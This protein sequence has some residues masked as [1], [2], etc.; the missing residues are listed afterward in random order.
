MAESKVV[1]YAALAGN[2]AI[3]AVKFVAAGLTGSSAMLSEAVHSV[4]D[5]V[6]QL[7]LLL[8]GARAGKAPDASHPFGYGLEAYFWGFV[9]ALMVFLLGGAVSAYEGWHKL[10]HPEPSGRAGVSY[11]VLGVSALFEAASFTVA[12]REYRKLAGGRRL[13]LLGFIK[14]SKDPNLF[15][16][17]LEDGAALTGLAIAA[18]GVTGQLLG[19]AWADAAA[20]MGIGALL[21]TVAAVLANETRSLIAGEAADPVVVQAVR[22][23]LGDRAAAVSEVATLQ[24][25]PERILVAV[26]LDM[27][28]GVDVERIAGELTRRVREADARVFRVYFRPAAGVTDAPAPANTA[29]S[30]PA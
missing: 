8:G 30:A 28:E 5:T 14:R 13:G 3:A 4:V 26:T 25:G 10:T 23:A 24:L 9:V 2:A 17:L 1:V 6:D 7:L 20:S 15:V 18:L 27:R 11:L 19:V 22:A 29:P 16:T 21:V 12:Y